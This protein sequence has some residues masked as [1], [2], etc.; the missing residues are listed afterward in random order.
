M[1][2]TGLIISIVGLLRP[3]WGGRGGGHGKETA[4]RISFASETDRQPRRS[5]H[6]GDDVSVVGG[7][8]GRNGG[9]E[10]EK[11]A[12]AIRDVLVRD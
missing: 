7:A 8:D 12:E 10:E 5:R 1:Q 6:D 9:G 3:T 4:S 11:A 2:Q